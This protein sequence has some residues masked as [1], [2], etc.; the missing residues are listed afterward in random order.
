MA[1]AEL[2]PFGFQADIF[3]HALNAKYI[4]DAQRKKGSKPI[5]IRDL[6]PGEIKT[7]EENKGSFVKSLKEFF[8]NRT[9]QRNKNGK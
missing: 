7:A 5:D 4:L 8:L 6:M 9:I 1:F 3:G 2:E